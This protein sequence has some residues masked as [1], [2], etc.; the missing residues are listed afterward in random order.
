DV[1]SHYVL[2]IDAAGWSVDAALAESTVEGARVAAGTTARVE[3]RAGAMTYT[4]TGHVSALDVDRLLQVVRGSPPDPRVRSQI[5]TAF[6]VDGAGPFASFVD[7]DVTAT[8]SMAQ[9]T[10]GGVE[11]EHLEAKGTLAERALTADVSGRLQ[12]VTLPDRGRAAP[13][14]LNGAIDA[15]VLW[16]DISAPVQP[17]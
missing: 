14:R 1:V 3:N 13:S 16:H 2:A 17:A 6:H 15:H 4:S 9:S 11:V 5:D 7:H 8:L 10:I 12:G